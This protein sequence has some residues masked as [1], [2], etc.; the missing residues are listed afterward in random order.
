M[1]G[2]EC[3]RVKAMYHRAGM[4]P[5][6]G[7]G[8]HTIKFHKTVTS[9]GAK[10]KVRSPHAVAMAKLGPGKAVRSEHRRYRK[11]V[12]RLAKRAA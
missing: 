9:I 5:P 6:K 4:K 7:K 8:I 12:R 2:K 1:P 3:R 10:G 11:N